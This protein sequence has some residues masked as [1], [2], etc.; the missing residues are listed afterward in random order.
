MTR[1]APE[2]LT[3]LRALVT[4]ELVLM[5]L[6]ITMGHLD[7]LSMACV[8][9]ALKITVYVWLV[10]QW[11][12]LMRLLVRFFVFLGLTASGG[13]I[14]ETDFLDPS[15]LAGW[16][17][18]AMALVYNRLYA[19]QGLDALY[20]IAD[21]FL[22]GL[23]ATAVVIAFA[24]F[25]IQVTVTLLEFY[26]LASII[27]VLIPFGFL[28]YTAFLAEKAIALVWGYA[29]K[30]LV[31][32]FVT[33]VAIPHV[34]K[35]SPGLN[36]KFAQVVTL[37][38]TSWAL[39]VLAWRAPALANALLHGAPQLTAETVTHAIRTTTSSVMTMAQTMRAMA[40]TPPT[41]SASQSPTPRRRP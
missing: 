1:V 3:L 2:A 36:P 8:T 22:T 33:G 15:A 4:I 20:N 10:T 17:T 39:V 16:G 29:V 6:W 13:V 28:K 27:I 37:A 11:P 19:Y 26:A 23:A 25:A 5:G 34:V 14:S 40:G 30:L 12:Q 9:I 18:S 32:S 21:I 7:G 31:L 24:V 41:G 38:I 35:M